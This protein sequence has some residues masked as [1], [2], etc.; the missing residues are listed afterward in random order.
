MIN[1]TKKY[2]ALI[3]IIIFLLITNFAM[4]LFFIIL[5]KP[6]DKRSKERTENGMSNSLKQDVGFSNDQLDQYQALRTLQRKN[7]KPL[8][9]K[10]RKSK[11]DF[12]EL[13]YLQNVSDSTLAVDA[14]SIAQTQKELDLQ[15]FNHFKKIRNICTPDQLQKFDSTIKKVIIRMTGRPGKGK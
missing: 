4:L 6:A 14:D 9:D 13:L 5:D 3:S 10:V 2:K 12:Y 8:F 11:I 1:D 7:V 15:M